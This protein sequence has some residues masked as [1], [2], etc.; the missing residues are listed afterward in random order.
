MVFTFYL[1][2]RS[3]RTQSS[4]LTWGILAGLAYG[5]MVAAWGGFIIVGNMVAIHAT[6]IVLLGYYSPN[7]YYAFTS[8]FIVGT[9]IAVNIPIVSWSPFSSLEQISLFCV[10]L[11]L[12]GIFICEWLSAKFFPNWSWG[13]NPIKMMTFRAVMFLIAGSALG[14]V[15]YFVLMPRNYFG[16]LTI[17]VK[18]LFIK[19]TKTGNPLVDSVAEH[20][21]ASAQAYQ[22]YLNDMYYV[23]PIGFAIISLL[24]IDRFLGAKR[25]YT[26]VHLTKWFIIL[27]ASI[28][29]YF[30]IK[31]SRLILLLGPVASVLSGIAFGF[32]LEWCF[33]E[34]AGFV[35]RLNNIFFRDPNQE[36]GIGRCAANSHTSLNVTAT[37]VN[38]NTFSTTSTTITVGST[39]KKKKGFSVRRVIKWVYNL[40]IFRIFRLA[41]IFLVFY[42]GF[43]QLAAFWEYSDH[44]AQQISQ[45]SLMYYARGRNGEKFL[46]NDYKDSYD[47]LRN[48]TAPDAR[49]L[50]W[51]DYGY[52]I[53]GIAN[54]TTIADGNTWNIEHIA[55]LGKILTSPEEK[56]HSLLDT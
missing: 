53:A 27:Y 11:A 1:W 28:S 55:L 7:L 49:I 20:Q 15:V 4:G 54:R 30:S 24:Y 12:Q 22:T 35:N 26:G 6:L 46:V 21:P 50:S 39:E 44:H 25:E 34:F 47:W 45:P 10:F 3:L 41:L 52:Q 38:G 40:M 31:M 37:T 33:S 32:F 17:R 36:T 9:T 5:Y 13:A 14:C 18:S 19:H 56:A 16:G 48:N 23:S 43:Y 8:F 2:C 42:Q 51:W 29:Y